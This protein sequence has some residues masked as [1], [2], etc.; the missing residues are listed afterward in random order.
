MSGSVPNFPEALAMLDHITQE[1]S[2]AHF[3]CRLR[4]SRNF[5]EWAA[6]SG[7]ELMVMYARRSC[8]DM[9]RQVS[10]VISNTK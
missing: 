8:H 5:G 4:W 9:G 3:A 1:M 6:S 2:Y 7:G 10:S